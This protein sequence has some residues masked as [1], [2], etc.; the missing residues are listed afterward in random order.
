M[1]N[2]FNHLQY[3]HT[4]RAF[5]HTSTMGL[6]AMALTS[7]L[8]EGSAQDANPLRPR[9]GHFPATTKAVRSN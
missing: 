6:G 5:L 3:S 9:P 8:N 2:E 4:R 1:N 7:L